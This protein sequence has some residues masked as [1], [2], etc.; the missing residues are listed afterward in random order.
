MNYKYIQNSRER[1]WRAF[2]TLI[3]NRLRKKDL[4]FFVRTNDIISTAPILFGD[5]EPHTLDFMNWASGVGYGDFL[6]DI[7]GSIGLS[8]C[9]VE[10][11]FSMICVFEPNPLAF[12]IL[13]VNVSSTNDESK[14]R[15]FHYGIGRDDGRR[16]LLIPKHNW[17]GA[18]I[19]GKDNRYSEEILAKKDNFD[20][21][22]ADNYLLRE[23]EIRKGAAVFSSLFDEILSVSSSA[24]GIIK[25]DVEG[26]ELT[27]IEELAK[28]LPRDISAILILE[29][30]DES[31]ELDRVR[32]AFGGRA[33]A[34]SFKRKSLFP[35]RMP[36]LVK[37]A[38]FP[39]VAIF[40]GGKITYSLE[41]I[42]ERFKERDIVGDL[43]LKVPIWPY[44]S[45]DQS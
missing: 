43:V 42:E 3:F 17:G 22:D 41:R 8:C 2:A 16:D 45:R 27:V 31:F 40:G 26:C 21:I 18:F 35:K 23:V 10:K 32:A 12:K 15:L 33:I 19:V 38:L 24:N 25:I 14:Y 9:P 7:G 36:L 28:S 4:R 39:I 20:S 13:E 1:F 37:M 6:F 5:Y 44:S 34:Y 29:N 30:W 11:L